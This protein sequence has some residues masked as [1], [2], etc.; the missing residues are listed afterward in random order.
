MTRRATIEK[1]GSIK[2]KWT[3]L[4]AKTSNCTATYSHNLAFVV[5][6]Y[7]ILLRNITDTLGMR[8][9]SCSGEITGNFSKY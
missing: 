4:A 8:S 1:N 3:Y 2:T 7:T 6:V 9:P 5:I